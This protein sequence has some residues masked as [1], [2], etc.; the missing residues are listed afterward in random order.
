M[1]FNINNLNSIKSKYPRN[2]TIQR[3]R[4]CGTK[5]WR[6]VGG[7][8]SPAL[9]HRLEGKKHIT[10]T[11]VL[12]TQL[13]LEARLASTSHV[14]TLPVFPL[15][16]AL[17]T[18]ICSEQRKSRKDDFG[19]F[20][21]YKKSQRLV[22]WEQCW[23][24]YLCTLASTAAHVAEFA[25]PAAPVLLVLLLGALLWH[26]AETMEWFAADLAENHLWRDK[27]FPC[28]AAHDDQWLIN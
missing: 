13:R 19:M 8:A 7:V 15:S 1:T 14:P 11:S 2:C 26:E 25:A 27:R 4:V 5:A 21:L 12:I 16:L 22:L 9:Q 10:E 6:M 20:V 28:T 24:A 23:L 17:S 18:T 3:L